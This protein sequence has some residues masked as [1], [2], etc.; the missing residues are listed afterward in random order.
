[1]HLYVLNII[2]SIVQDLRRI[3]AEGSQIPKPKE[4]FKY[5]NIESSNIIITLRT[6]YGGCS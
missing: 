5:Y 6:I 2:T 1:L 3:F 4:C